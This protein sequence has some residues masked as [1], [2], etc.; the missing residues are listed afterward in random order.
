MKITDVEISERNVKSAPDR[1]AAEGETSAKDIKHIFDRLPEF[2]AEKHNALVDY[3]K[4]NFYLKNEVEE[5]VKSRADAFSNG[6]MVKADYDTDNNGSVDNADKVN[7]FWFSF[8]DAE[9]NP[10]DE[11]YIHW[12]E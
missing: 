8:T 1:L 6:T 4:N 9:G 3:I 11:P 12:Y 7:G 2:I 5:V 10:T